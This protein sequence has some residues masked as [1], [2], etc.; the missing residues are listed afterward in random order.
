M[1][2]NRNGSEKP[3]TN[4]SKYK[5]GESPLAF[6]IKRMEEK[7]GPIHGVHPAAKPRPTKK[8]EK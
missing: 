5:L 7:I 8:E 1:E 4:K 3:R 6:P 2:T